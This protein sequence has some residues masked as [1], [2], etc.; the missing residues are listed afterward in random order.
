[1]AYTFSNL[2]T[3]I[4]N[5]TEVDSD[6][7]SDSVLTT[8]VKNAENRI[9]READSDDNVTVRFNSN[10]DPRDRQ[11]PEY[12]AAEAAGKE[13]VKAAMQYLNSQ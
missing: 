4:R 10:F 13:F 11:G 7:L 6:V 5:Y 9:Y 3:D 8:I 2:K 1:M 12:E